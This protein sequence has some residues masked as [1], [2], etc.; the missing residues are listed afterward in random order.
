MNKLR[1]PI[2]NPCHEDWD[3]MH[4]EGRGSRFC[5]QCAKSVHN[6][7]EMTESD[8]HALLAKPRGADGLCIRYTAEADGRVRFRSPLDPRSRTD[9]L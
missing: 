6:L 5:D 7:S 9:G 1:L 8:A 4:T 2:A 3:A